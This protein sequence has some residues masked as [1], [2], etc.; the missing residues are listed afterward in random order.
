MLAEAGRTNEAFSL[1]EDQDS[2]YAK[3]YALLGTAQ[4]IMERVE[5]EQK[6]SAGRK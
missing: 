2:P 6:A 3:T 5:S 4:G 1:A